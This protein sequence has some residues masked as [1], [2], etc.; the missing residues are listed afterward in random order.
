MN[1]ANEGM[2]TLIHL[3]PACAVDINL[4]C[5]QKDA[6][7]EGYGSFLLDARHDARVM[8]MVRTLARE[9]RVP[10]TCKIRLLRSETTGV[11]DL[12]RTIAYAQQLEAA[13]CSLLAVHGRFRGGV[14]YRRRGA[15]DLS[16]IAAIKAAVGIPVLCNG[17]TSTLMCVRENLATTGCEGVMSCEV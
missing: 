10:V 2:Y 1:D 12:A 6:M 3:S 4:G 14:R 11:T 7:N 16:A 9:L 17:N 8:D 5:P 13:G 15:A